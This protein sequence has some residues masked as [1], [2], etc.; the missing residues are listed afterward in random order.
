[1]RARAVK[2]GGRKVYVS[3]EVRNGQFQIAGGKKGMKI[4][5]QVSGVRHDRF[6]VENPLQVEGEKK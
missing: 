6:A 2:P 4:S 3:R 5:W 1:V